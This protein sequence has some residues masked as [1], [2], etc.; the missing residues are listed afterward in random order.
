M[1]NNTEKIAEDLAFSTNRATRKR[2]TKD[3]VW[4][5]ALEKLTGLIKTTASTQTEAVLNQY[6]AKL[7][8]LLELLKPYGSERVLKNMI[9]ALTNKNLGSYMNDACELTAAMHFLSL[10]ES[11]F[12][13]QVETDSSEASTGKNF[14][15]AFTADSLTFNVEVKSFAPEPLDK[16]RRAAKSFLPR[17]WT[18]SL[19]EQGA[20]FEANCMPAL[21]RLMDKANAQ[22]PRKQG[23]HN[24][25]LLSCND[26][27][28]FADVLT[29]LLGPF[30][31]CRHNE[32]TSGTPYLAKYPNIDTVVINLIGLQ[33][34]CVLDPT[35]QS[36][37]LPASTAADL[38]GSNAWTY[39]KAFP[40]SV[41]LRQVN[42]PQTQSIALGRSFHLNDKHYYQRL[43][44]YREDIQSAFFNLFNEAWPSMFYGSY[45]EAAALPANAS[46]GFVKS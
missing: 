3:E 42:L 34:L 39:T 5:E 21:M 19:V 32:P 29:C 31:I 18:H 7:C 44:T 43:S 10:P 36:Q 33:H 30:G 1:S 25:M 40:I 41:N 13:Y 6:T 23:E 24:V 28:E 2:K 45:A 4:S 37:F 12:R 20:E 22:L 26:P 11:C 14:D 9:T 27:D 17:V 46:R 38:N 15:I 8:E 35:Y 16:E